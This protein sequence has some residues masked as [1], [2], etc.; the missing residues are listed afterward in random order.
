[1]PKGFEGSYI[2]STKNEYKFTLGQIIVRYGKRFR[3]T[4]INYDRV[5]K[6]WDIY[7]V[8]VHD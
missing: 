1:M 3:I 8:E 6:V 2:E 7:G 4:A 5:N